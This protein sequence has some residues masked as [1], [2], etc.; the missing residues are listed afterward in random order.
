MRKCVDIIENGGMKSVGIYRISGKKEDCL[1][2]QEKFDN[3]QL[4]KV[5]I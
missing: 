3:G 5:L 4:E 2:L 1:T